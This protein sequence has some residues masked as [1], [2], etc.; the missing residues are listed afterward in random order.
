VSAVL[1]AVQLWALEAN[2]SADSCGLMT[3]KPKIIGL[4][5]ITAEFVKKDLSGIEAGEVASS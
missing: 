5:I 2:I 4:Y 1:F 3:Y